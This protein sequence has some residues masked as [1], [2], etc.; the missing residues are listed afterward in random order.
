MHQT[1]N[2]RNGLILI[3][4]LF[5]GFCFSQIKLSYDTSKL[6]NGNGIIYF[7]GSDEKNYG[8]CTYKDGHLNG[9]YYYIDTLEQTA[10][11]GN[12]QYQPDCV[13]KYAGIRIKAISQKGDTIS[14]ALDSSQM[15]KLLINSNA[16]ILEKVKDS[17]AYGAEAH[18]ELYINFG[19]P[20]VVPTGHWLRFDL[21]NKYIFGEFDFDDCGNVLVATY[22]NPDGSISNQQ[23]VPPRKKRKE[24]WRQR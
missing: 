4:G 13:E 22:F 24:F 18:P 10:F 12:V 2:F 14:I 16:K 9:E 23:K 5:P 20:A 7:L 17:I 19:D 6:I 8:F 21:A 11:L 3:L 1:S 15:E